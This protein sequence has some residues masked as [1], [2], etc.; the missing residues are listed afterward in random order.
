MNFKKILNIRKPPMWYIIINLLNILKSNTKRNF[1]YGVILV[2]STEKG[3]RLGDIM[4]S[5][6]YIKNYP[7]GM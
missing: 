2:C 1:K 3:F 7:K 4:D 6:R 5:Y